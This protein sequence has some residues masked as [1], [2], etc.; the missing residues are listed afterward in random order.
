MSKTNLIKR[1]MMRIYSDGDDERYILLEAEHKGDIETGTKRGRDG[2]LWDA[3]DAVPDNLKEEISKLSGEE[4]LNATCR[5]IDPER[6]LFQYVKWVKPTFKTMD[7][8]FTNIKDDRDVKVKILYAKEAVLHCAR[9]YDEKDIKNFDLEAYLY[10]VIGGT[11]EDEVGYLDNNEFSSERLL[12]EV[13]HDLALNETGITI[14]DFKMTGKDIV[15]QDVSVLDG[16]R[17]ILFTLY[18]DPEEIEM[19]WNCR[20]KSVRDLS[21]D[22]H[23]ER[24][25]STNHWVRLIAASVMENMPGLIGIKSNT[26][27]TYFI[28]LETSAG[29]GTFYFDTINDKELDIDELEKIVNKTYSDLKD[30][31][32]I[33]EVTDKITD[34]INDYDDDIV[35]CDWFYE[36]E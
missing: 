26:G 29:L 8:T 19:C 9:Y 13:K 7:F 3:W 36:D 6:K 28:E 24:C 16:E 34:I 2:I 11:I 15:Y 1:S 10:H 35:N 4:R 5:A 21:E 23:R 31:Y 17:H 22:V 27:Y 20:E 14:I 18:I 30:K 25:V 33:D 12:G 32:S